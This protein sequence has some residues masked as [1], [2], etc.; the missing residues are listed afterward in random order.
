VG[1]AGVVRARHRGGHAP[2]DRAEFVPFDAPPAP[3]ERMA[4]WPGHHPAPAPTTSIVE[5][6]PVALLDR[7]G[8]SVSVGVR[9]ALSSEPAR[10]GFASG[11][12]TEVIWWAGP[13]PLVERWWETPRRRAHLQVLTRDGRAFLLVFEATRWWLA[14]VYD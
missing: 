6:A 5:P 1:V 13:W 3:S 2:E 14:G 7:R 9:G 4:P 10:L 8:A 12:V 11:L